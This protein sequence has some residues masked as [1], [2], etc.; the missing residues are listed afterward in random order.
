MGHVQH[1]RSKQSNIQ[2]QLPKHGDADMPV[3]P[4]AEHTY[5]SVPPAPRAQYDL[6]REV[7]RHTWAMPFP[8][9]VF[10]CSQ[11]TRTQLKEGK[12][13]TRLDIKPRPFFFLC[14]G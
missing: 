7:I 5:R 12:A 6:P 8:P 3:T 11:S 13:K 1:A 14:Y 4:D 10:L 2:G 9:S